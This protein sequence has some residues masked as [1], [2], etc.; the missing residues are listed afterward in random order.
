MYPYGDMISHRNAMSVQSSIRRAKAPSWLRLE[1]EPSE[2]L[3]REGW[4]RLREGG[5]LNLLVRRKISQ[6]LGQGDVKTLSQFGQL[7]AIQQLLKILPRRLQT[8]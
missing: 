5:S 3:V 4:V 8:A 2:A 6:V 1:E 7:L